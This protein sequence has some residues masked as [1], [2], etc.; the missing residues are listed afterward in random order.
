M[1]NYEI[2]WY[3]YSQKMKQKYK[4]MQQRCGLTVWSIIPVRMNIEIILAAPSPFFHP[5]CPLRNGMTIII[6]DIFHSL[7]FITLFRSARLVPKITSY[8]S[9]SMMMMVIVNPSVTEWQCLS[10]LYEHFSNCWYSCV[11]LGSC[12]ML[13]SVFPYW[14]SG[15]PIGPI[16]KGLSDPSKWDQKS[17]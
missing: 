13:H 2:F 3:C 16:F 8:L 12:G 9:C 14:L 17:V 11:F 4:C 10:I 7:H 6:S 1:R 5:I 15:Q